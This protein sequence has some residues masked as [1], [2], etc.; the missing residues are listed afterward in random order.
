M[1]IWLREFGGPGPRYFETPQIRSCLPARILGWLQDRQPLTD[2]QKFGRRVLASMPQ[3][4]SL[5]IQSGL[6]WYN[7]LSD[8]RLSLRLGAALAIQPVVCPQINS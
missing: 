5:F 3:T 8:Q 4:P 6:L 1:R 2:G 7:L